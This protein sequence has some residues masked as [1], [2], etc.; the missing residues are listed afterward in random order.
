MYCNY[1]DTD[2][3]VERKLRY[4]LKGEYTL[5]EFTVRVGMPYP[6]DVSK[7]SFPVCDGWA[8]C[9]VDVIGMDEDY[10]EVYGGDALQALHLA[11][12]IEPFLKRLQDKYDIYDVSGEP[13]FEQ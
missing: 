4:S 1:I 3:L 7:V 11:T 5:K 2:F 6:L 13:Y 9:H 10:P 8:G 12:N